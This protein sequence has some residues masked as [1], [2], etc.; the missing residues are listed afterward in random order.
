MPGDGGANGCSFSGSAGAFTLSAAIIANIGTALAG[1]YAYFSA[2]FGGS[3]LP[4]GWYW[5]KFSSDTEGVVYADTYTSGTP[6]RPS[7]D[8]PIGVNLTGR[9]TATTNEVVGP[10]GFILPGG[11]L[12]KNGALDVFFSHS[13]STS[14]TKSA[15][16]I[17]DSTAVA[18]VGSTISPVVDTMHRIT[19]IDSDTEKLC[20]RSSVAAITSIATAGG[21]YSSASYVSVDTSV[22]TVISVSLKQSAST[23]T[24]ILLSMRVS[25]TYG[26]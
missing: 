19:C 20:G 11:A 26:D 7:S 10:A 9:I 5:T 1:C 13:G 18:S 6:R 2:N 15:K 23:A 4:A 14:G 17:I 16:A 3:T 12:G 22:D 25:A 24:P 8:T 21:T